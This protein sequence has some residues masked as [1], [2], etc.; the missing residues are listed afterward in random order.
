MPARFAP[1]FRRP[2]GVLLLFL[3]VTL[4]V[5]SPAL[6]GEF[7][8][9]DN[10]LIKGNGLVRSP[11]FCLEVFRHTLFEGSSNFYRPVQTLTYMWDYAW[12]GMNP[13]GYHLTNALIH[14]ANGFG[15]CLLLRRLLPGLVSAEAVRTPATDRYA[16]ALALVWVVHPVHSAAVAYIAG[17]ADSLAMGFCVSA[18]L[19]CIR[20]LS[21]GDKPSVRAGAA[22][23]AFACF[24]AGLCS[25]EIAFVWLALFAGWLVAVRPGA[26]RRGRLLAIAGG[27]AAVGISFGLRHLPPAAPVPPLPPDTVSRW[28]L[29][30]RAL[31]D[32]G[33]LMLF[34]D[35]LYMERQ[36]FAAPGLANPADPTYY[37]ALAV[38]GA[39][40]L[41]AFA[42]GAVLPGCGRQLRRFGA[43]WFL[44]G[45]LPISN[46]FPLNASVAEHWLYLPSIGFLLFLAGV[47]LD[48]PWPRLSPR[49]ARPGIAAAAVAVAVAAL[50]GRTWLRAHDWTD[51]LTFYR[52]TIRDGGDFPRMR[53]GLALACLERGDTTTAATLLGEL[54]K[55][56][57]QLFSARV[58]LA[59]AQLRTGRTDEARAVLE[60]VAA[61]LDASNDRRAGPGEFVATIRALDRLEPTGDPAWA[62]LRPRLLDHVARRFTSSWE[63]VRLR[64]A[65]LEKSGDLPVAIALVQRFA[66][67][68]WWHAPA[69]LELGRLLA[70]AGRSDEAL[71]A[72]R[73]AARFDLHDAGA[74]SSAAALCLAQG[75]LDEALAWQQAAV[76]RQPGSLRQHL[77]LAWVLD[78]HGRAADADHERELAARLTQAGE[79]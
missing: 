1:F 46:L 59:T 58:N 61:D 12:W 62:V 19:L 52:Q 33:R 39:L 30:F 14:A 43:A 5:Y 21:T 23:G 38:A 70:A 26:G 68:C 9:D 67:G 28:V 48:V 66:D 11:Y 15:L 55:G 49:L 56:R 27:L 31:G 20:A 44:A 36:V 4:V 72:W 63:P 8:W 7:L 35:E 32:Y 74:F 2:A 34:P 13:F 42:A 79:S 78:R 47:A 17:R 37:T 77:L 75:H 24:L 51:S 54:V 76:H 73:Q 50:G 18:W 60:G 29:M 57:P 45:F 3:A 10:Y 6:G 64:A 25:K 22:A 71:A 69:R 16:L 53:E 41:A 65:D 40:V